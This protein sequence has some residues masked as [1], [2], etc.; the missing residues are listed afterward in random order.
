VAEEREERPS[1]SREFDDEF[2]TAEGNRAFFGLDVLRGLVEGIDDFI[3]REPPVRK[4]HYVSDPALLGSAMWIDD[5]ELL[6]KI[7]R[8]AGACIVVTKQ[9]R[10]DERGKLRPLRELNDR[11]P[12]LPIRAFPDLGGLAPKVEGAPLVVGPYTSMDD[13]VVP[14]IRTLGFRKRGDLVPIMHAKLALLGH[15]WWTDD[16][17]LGGEEIWFKPRRLWV[18]SANF[19]SRSRDSLEFGYWTEDAALVEGAKRFLLK[20]IA[21]SEDLDAEADHLDPDLAPVEFDEAAIAEA[22]A[23]T[24]WGPDEDEEV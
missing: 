20:A 9:P 6:S 15:L 12:P 1:F 3:E 4:S 16:G 19:T 17:W 10:K 24:D 8:L 11:M 5:P 22:F 18:S 23:E 13:G 2:L 7:E 14:T 21:S